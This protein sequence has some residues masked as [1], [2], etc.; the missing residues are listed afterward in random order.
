MWRSILAITYRP[1]PYFSRQDFSLNPGLTELARPGNPRDPPVSIPSTWITD[2]TCP[3][4]LLCGC[5]RSQLG[6]YTCVATAFTWS[7][8]Q[9]RM[10]LMLSSHPLLSISTHF[11]HLANIPWPSRT[12]HPDVAYV[13]SPIWSHWTV[14]HLR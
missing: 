10:F 11:C 4:W 1:S 12:A 5:W 9:P 13:H 7:I 2:T 3:I 8:L 14:S 6:L